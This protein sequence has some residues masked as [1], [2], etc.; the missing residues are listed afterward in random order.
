MFVSD[1][2]DNDDKDCF[3]ADHSLGG[4]GGECISE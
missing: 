3:Q 2:N 4:G 1:D